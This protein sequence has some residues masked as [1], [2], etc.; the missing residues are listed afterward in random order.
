MGY[1]IGR[2]GTSLSRVRCRHPAFPLPHLGEMF[3]SGPRSK[4]SGSLITF[5]VGL[6]A[7][8]HTIPSHLSWSEQSSV[9]RSSGGVG[10]SRSMA[11]NARRT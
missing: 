10:S 11:S 9:G 5:H 3:V 7:G 1:D 2:R 6:K 4:P 8:Q